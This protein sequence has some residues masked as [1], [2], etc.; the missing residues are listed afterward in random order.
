MLR[1]LGFAIFVYFL[2]IRGF[3]RAEAPAYL[4]S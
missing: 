4:S 1:K 3:S 2:S